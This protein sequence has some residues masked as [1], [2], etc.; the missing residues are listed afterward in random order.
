MHGI[1]IKL[2]Y[3]KLYSASAFVHMVNE[4]YIYNFFCIVS[5][6][7]HFIPTELLTRRSAVEGCSCLLTVEYMLVG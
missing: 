2:S 7:Q 3:D 4:I 5:D 1:N 6:L